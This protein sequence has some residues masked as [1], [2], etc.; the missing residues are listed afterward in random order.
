MALTPLFKDFFNDWPFEDMNR[1][2]MM[3]PSDLR[4]FFA[5]RVDVQEQEKDIIIHAE[6]PGVPKENISLNFKD[7]NLEISGKK[8]EKKEEH[9]AK[10]HRI[11]SRAGEFRRVIALP[12]G[13]RNEDISASSKDGVLQITVKKSDKNLYQPTKI[14]IE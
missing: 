10:W 12:K 8:E 13:T 6:I 2:S 7:G 11:E 3:V 9:N 14:A 1:H 4:G 5:P